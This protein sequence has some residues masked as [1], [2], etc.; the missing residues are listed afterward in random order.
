[1][2]PKFPSSTDQVPENPEQNK[3]FDEGDKEAIR[4]PDQ[5]TSPQSTTA[6][7]Y[8]KPAK[9]GA[10]QA[11]TSDDT[12]GHGGAESKHTVVEIWGITAASLGLGLSHLLVFKTLM[13]VLY[14]VWDSIPLTSATAF[15]RFPVGCVWYTLCCVSMLHYHKASFTCSPVGVTT[16]KDVVVVTLTFALCTVVLAG[17]PLHLGAAIFGLMAENIA[18]NGWEAYLKKKG[19]WDAQSLKAVQTLDM[20]GNVVF[21]IGASFSIAYPFMSR[22]MNHYAAAAIQ[23]VYFI[24]LQQAADFTANFSIRKIGQARDGGVPFA[25]IQHFAGQNMVEGFKFASLLA[26]CADDPDNWSWWLAMFASTIVNTTSRLGWVFQATKKLV[27]SHQVVP[28]TKEMLAWQARYFSGYPKLGA[29]VSMM[30]ARIMLGTAGG[31]PFYFNTNL[32]FCMLGAALQMLMEDLVVHVGSRAGLEPKFTSDD[33]AKQVPDP[34]FGVALTME[35]GVQKKHVVYS[36]PPLL[37][38]AGLFLHAVHGGGCMAIVG[39]LNAMGFRYVAG[40]TEQHAFSLTEGFFLWQM[41]DSFYYD[42]SQ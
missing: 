14:I 5:A 35:E 29:P 9:D 38:T 6:V 10:T 25:E 3:R 8:D 21:A 13:F 26:A 17:L 22:Y 41:P 28:R 32:A 30:L 37:E 42:G 20:T 40:L 36:H 15:L 23:A 16:T 31:V 1:M 2:A 11:S 33:L 39:M 34:V 18:L 4:N 12:N 7:N 27:K 19:F 24:V